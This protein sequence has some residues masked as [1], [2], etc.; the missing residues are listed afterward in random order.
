MVYISQ[1]VHVWVV[2]GR[3]QDHYH[4][5]ILALSS[6]PFHSGAELARTPKAM[7]NVNGECDCSSPERRVDVSACEAGVKDIFLICRS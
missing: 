1:Y 5:C 4:H 6:V 3:L 7:Q 2:T